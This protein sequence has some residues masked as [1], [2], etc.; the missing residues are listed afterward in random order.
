[1]PDLPALALLFTALLLAALLVAIV[2]AV[3]VRRHLLGRGHGFDMAVRAR[4]QAATGRGW[5]FGVARYEEDRLEWFRTFSLSPRPRRV[6]RRSA[7][8]VVSQRPVTAAESVVV[9]PGHVVV[10][11]RHAGDEVDLSMTD[12][13]L[14]GLLAWTEAAPPG[15]ERV[16]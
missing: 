3:L 2:T 1:V 15:R 7:F 14:T 11:C 12:P 8:Q 9:P 4:R 10:A 6:F 5:S 16:A 13:A